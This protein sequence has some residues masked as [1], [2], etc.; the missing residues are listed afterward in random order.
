MGQQYSSLSIE[1]RTQLGLLVQQR[2]T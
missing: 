1:E 2:L